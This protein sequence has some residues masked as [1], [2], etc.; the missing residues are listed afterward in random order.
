[1][2]GWT[3]IHGDPAHSVQTATAGGISIS[4]VSTSN[5]SPN[6][7]GDCA[8]DGYG[9]SSGTYF[10]SAVMQDSWIQYNGSGNNLALYNELVPQLQ[11]SSL[12]PD[13]T[14]TLRMT[15]SNVYFAN[16]TVY[17]V[18]GASVVGSQVL[19][20]FD[21]ITQGI[22]FLK[23]APNSSGDINIY[24][25]CA[26]GLTGTSFSWI[27]GLCRFTPVPRVSARRVVAIS[28]PANGTLFP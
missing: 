27:S 5:W 13:S 23:V 8:L 4:S 1:M 12:N 25:N 2:S 26:S 15:G 18:V 7:D 6:S 3:N 9:E 21:N 16:T 28:L 11:L 19:T 24:V 20:T 14:Y 17:T 22:T 10:P